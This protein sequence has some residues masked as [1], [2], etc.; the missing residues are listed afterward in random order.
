MVVGVDAAAASASAVGGPPVGHPAAALGSGPSHSRGTP[1][2]RLRPGTQPLG[3]GLAG[4]PL[5]V[6]SPRVWAFWVFWGGATGPPPSLRVRAGPAA[7]SWGSSL[8][9]VSPFCGLPARGALAFG[10][11][12]LLAAP[13][14]A[15]RFGFGLGSVENYTTYSYGSHIQPVI[16]TWGGWG[17]P[18]QKPIIVLIFDHEWAVYRLCLGQRNIL[19]KAWV[20]SFGVKRG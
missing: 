12:S 14:V 13:D 8:W 9:A 6:L 18:G 11:G 2:L 7:A 3:G 15:G 5:P 20:R 19:Y 17:F 16:F 1:P 10:P 4:P